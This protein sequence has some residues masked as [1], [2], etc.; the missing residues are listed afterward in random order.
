MQTQALADEDVLLESPEQAAAKLKKIPL[1]EM[2]GP[3][4]QGEGAVIGLQTY[5]MRFGLCDYKCK[6]CDSMHAVDPKQVK[7]NAQWIDQTEIM[8]Q[9]LKLYKENTTR[10]VTFSG[11]NPCIHD[12]TR[13]VGLLVESYYMIAVETQGT[14]CPEWLKSCHIVTVSPKG[15]GMGERLELDK[16]DIFMSKLASCNTGL[17]YNMKVVIFDQRD[18]EMASMLLERYERFLERGCNDFYLSLGNPFPPGV[19]RPHNDTEQLGLLINTYKMLFE[20]IQH[21]PNLCRVKFLPQW[22]TFL[23]GQEKGR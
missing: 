8:L 10:W 19:E 20:D 11:G 15:P 23:W 13:L 2:F 6:M 12:L 21:D 3:T 17:E 22:H 14:F 18:L 16:L 5:F 9:F 4:I 1:I 7:E